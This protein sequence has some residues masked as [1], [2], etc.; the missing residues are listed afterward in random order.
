M[1]KEKRYLV[2]VKY[3]KIVE[4]NISETSKDKAILKVKSLMDTYP[5]RLED[6]VYKVKERKYSA[7]KIN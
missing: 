6:N 5:K 1:N 2:T 3:T 7:I 4:F